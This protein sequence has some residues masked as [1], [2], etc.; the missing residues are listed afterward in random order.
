MNFNE[1]L[2][3]CIKNTFKKD[4]I[5]IYSVKRL[6][7]SEIF[8][9]GD[10]ILMDTREAGVLDKIWPSFYQM[11]GDIGRMGIVLNHD[12]ITVN[13]NHNHNHN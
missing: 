3:N 11:R 12:F 4:I 1:Y 13:H 7:D 9:I 2:N 10:D 6:S 8:T 5:E